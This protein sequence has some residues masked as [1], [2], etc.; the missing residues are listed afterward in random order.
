LQ[1]KVESNPEIPSV[2]YRTLVYRGTEEGVLVNVN[3][4]ASNVTNGQFYFNGAKMRLETIHCRC[5]GR[6]R[7]DSLSWVNRGGA[8]LCR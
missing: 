1:D 4:M 8:R 5:H 3:F 7:H 6:R 2:K